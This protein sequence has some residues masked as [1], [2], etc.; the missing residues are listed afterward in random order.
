MLRDGST[1]QYVNMNMLWNGYKN[2][3]ALGQSGR[4][5]SSGTDLGIINM[6]GAGSRDLIKVHQ[7]AR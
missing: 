7:C 4:T 2:Y 5:I 1:D 6:F 3:H